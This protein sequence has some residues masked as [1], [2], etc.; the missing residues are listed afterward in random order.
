[1]CAIHELLLCRQRDADWL[2]KAHSY[3]HFLPQTPLSFPLPLSQPTPLPNTLS[4]L[5]F[6]TVSIGLQSLCSIPLF[7]PPTFRYGDSGYYYSVT[8]M[9]RSNLPRRSVM[10]HK[11]G[12][13]LLRDGPA[14]PI[15]PI[16]GTS[17]F[18]F[19]S[20]FFFFFFFGKRGFFLEYRV[21][22]NS[23]SLKM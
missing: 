19:L 17:F 22:A 23:F 18:F 14:A 12:L 3:L 16:V 21:W 7:F 6:H 2:T 9:T 1:M 20:F 13:H 5:P 10:Q 4:F 15:I 8:A 11:R